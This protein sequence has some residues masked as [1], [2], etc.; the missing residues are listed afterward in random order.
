MKELIRKHAA[1]VKSRIDQYRENKEL[2]SRE[3][4]YLFGTQDSMDILSYSG[5]EEQPNYLIIDGRY[6]RTLAITGFPSTA[7]IGWLDNLINFHGDIDVSYHIESVDAIKALPN[8]N[9]KVTELESNRRK[10]EGNGEIVDAS[11]LDPLVS[12]MELRDNIRRGKEKLFLISISATI[13]AATL[14]ELNKKSKLLE[15]VLSAHLFY[16]KDVF[17]RQLEGL[18]TILPR[19]ED[20][21]KQKRNLDSSSAALTFPFVSSELAHEDGILYGVNLFN[22]SLVILDRY[23]L[24]NANSIIFAQSGSGKSYTAKVEIVR[25]MMQGT[26]VIVI[27]PEREYANLCEANGGTYVKLSATSEQKINPLDLATSSH[28]KNQLS[29]HAQELIEIISLMAGTADGSNASAGL[30]GRERAALDKAI[31]A[32][33]KNSKKGETPLLS[34]LYAELNNLGQ[35]VLCERLERYLSGTLAGVFN[36]PTNVDLDNRLVVFDIQELDGPLKQIMM[37]IISNF[38]QNQV[39]SKPE[40]RLLVIDE[41]WLMLEHEQSAKF[42]AGLVRRARKYYLGVAIISQQANDFLDN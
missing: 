16:T 13:S 18:Q 17:W 11:L 36:E 5:L 33:Y 38:V 14:E 20:W 42:V 22:N 34:D 23:A 25:Q 12:A 26:R 19:G 37:M 3:R 40:K 39:K 32:A 6:V 35:K 21:L 31:M 29:E 8:L 7:E 15:T 1:T 2:K 27:D 10:K 28:S 41:A 9:R 4:Q 24:N 30:N